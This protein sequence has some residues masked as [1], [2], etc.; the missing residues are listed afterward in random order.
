METLLLALA[1]VVPLV[2]VLLSSAWLNRRN[3]ARL[4]AGQADESLA[5]ATEITDKI[6]RQWIIDLRAELEKTQTVTR[7]ALAYIQRLVD[8]GQDNIRPD[9]EP[10][11]PVPPDLVKHL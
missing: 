11:P 8:W 5:K 7:A 2:G 3:I 6:A 1:V 9:A 4:T 10:M